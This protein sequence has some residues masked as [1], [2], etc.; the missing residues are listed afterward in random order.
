MASAPHA[1]VTDLL[2]ALITSIAIASITSCVSTVPVRS[3]TVCASEDSAAQRYVA[4]WTGLA[5]GDDRWVA[6][7]ASPFV[8]QVVRSEAIASLE[9]GC[10]SITAAA[11]VVHIEVGLVLRLLALGLAQVGDASLHDAARRL[12]ARAQIETD[13]DIVRALDLVADLERSSD[14]QTQRSLDRVTRLWPT[15]D[16]II[17]SRT[18]G[19]AVR[20]LHAPPPRPSEASTLHLD[21][22]PPSRNELARAAIASTRAWLTRVDP[23]AALG[24]VCWSGQPMAL[25]FAD[26]TA[27]AAYAIGMGADPADVE[28]LTLDALREVVR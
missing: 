17:G 15:S 9:E 4:R 20:V 23:G 10:V 12:M 19:P 27:I 21:P 6:L 2:R 14:E 3:T 24:G 5:R 26:P 13:A 8:Q 11:R 22:R 7:V 28:T 1:E 16:P 18:P 25:A